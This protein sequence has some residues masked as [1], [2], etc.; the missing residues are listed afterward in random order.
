MLQTKP[1]NNKNLKIE[2]GCLKMEEV[3]L[4]YAVFVQLNFSL[5]GQKG[6]KKTDKIRNKL[7]TFSLLYR[8]VNVFLNLKLLRKI[9]E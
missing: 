7:R 3:F 1:K 5:P 4:L 6:F 9:Y 2:K 8:L